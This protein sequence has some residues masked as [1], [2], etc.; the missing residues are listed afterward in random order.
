MVSTCLAAQHGFF[1]LITDSLLVMVI[2]GN[3]TN[4][5]HQGLGE[6]YCKYEKK[7]TCLKPCVAPEGALSDKLP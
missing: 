3:S 2:K 6:N 7:K 5:T 1:S 4:F